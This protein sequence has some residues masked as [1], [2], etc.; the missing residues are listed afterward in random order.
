M[1][2]LT[3]SAVENL[4]GKTV[5]AV[6]SRYRDSRTQQGVGIVGEVVAYAEHADGRNVYDINAEIN[7]EIFG[8]ARLFPPKTIRFIGKD[9]IGEG[10]FEHGTVV[11]LSKDGKPAEIYKF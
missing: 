4:V 5:V 2:P 3:E 9:V 7:G 10:N 1:K 6:L 11:E 8:S